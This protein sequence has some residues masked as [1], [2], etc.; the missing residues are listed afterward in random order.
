M[1]HVL[2]VQLILVRCK[3]QLARNDSSN[4]YSTKANSLLFLILLLMV[5]LLLLPPP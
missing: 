1:P 2:Q 5:L 3:C 4:T